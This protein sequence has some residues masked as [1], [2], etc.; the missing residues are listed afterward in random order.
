MKIRLKFKVQFG[1][2]AV[3]QMLFF[4]ENF[5]EAIKK[6]ACDQ[7]CLKTAKHHN[8]IRKYLKMLTKSLD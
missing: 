6:R 7:T 5:Y 1:K 3:D 2:R 4:P 8:W